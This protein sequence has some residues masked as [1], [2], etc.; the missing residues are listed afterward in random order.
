MHAK[1]CSSAQSAKMRCAVLCRAVISSKCSGKNK[2]QERKKRKR[3]TRQEK[4]KTHTHTH[5]HTVPRPN[6]AKQNVPETGS[7]TFSVE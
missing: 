4:Q 6:T 3:K 2:G 5:T 7:A 1:L